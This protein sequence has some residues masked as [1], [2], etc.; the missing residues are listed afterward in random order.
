MSLINLLI[1]ALLA[2]ATWETLKMT[3]QQ[4]K[5]SIDKLGALVVGIVIALSTGIDLLSLLEITTN[6]IP[7]LGNILTGILISRGANFMHDFLS[8]LGNIYQKNKK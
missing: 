8:S 2:E 1:L 5:I 6:K 7:S 3:W 4:G